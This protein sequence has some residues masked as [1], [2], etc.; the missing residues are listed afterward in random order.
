MH[1]KILC[2]LASHHWQQFPASR[3]WYASIQ[4]SRSVPTASNQTAMKCSGS[5]T[6][7]V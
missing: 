2:F 4:A 5:G 6:V 1:P 3:E 7:S